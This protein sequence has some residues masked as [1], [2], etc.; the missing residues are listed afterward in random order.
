[1]KKIIYLIGIWCMT[2]LASCDYLNVDPY[3]ND[4][5]NLDS[6]FARKSFIERYL[7]NAAAGIPEESA[8]WNASYPYNGGSDDAFFTY[9]R[10]TYYHNYFLAN[11]WDA[12]TSYFSNWASHYQ[13][14]RKANTILSRL[15]ECKDATAIEKKNIMGMARFL[16]GYFYYKLLEQY[17]PVVIVPETPQQFD[18]PLS[19]LAIPRSTYDEC[20][21]YI[22]NDLT[23][24]AKLLPEKQ[25]NTY[26]MRPTQGAAL[27]VISR[28]RLYAASPLYNGNRQF[29]SGW[30]TKDGKNFISPEENNRKWA[31]A[32]VAALK[33]IRLAEDKGLYSLHTKPATGDTPTLPSNVPSAEFP[34]GAGGIDPYHSYAD[35]FN[36][37]ALMYKNT[38]CIWG[39]EE[40]TAIYRLEQTCHPRSSGGW[41][42]MNAPQKLVD[43]YYMRD[44]G[45]IRKSGGYYN[46]SEI[47]YTDGIENFS[48]YTLPSGTFKMYANREYR[49]YATIMFNGAIFQGLSTSQPESYSNFQVN[50]MADGND[51]KNTANDP[52]DRLLSGY[53]FRKYT[54]PDDN[55]YQ[56]NVS[57]KA[58]ARFRY[59]EIL[60]NYV[61]ALNELTGTYTI[62]GYTVKRDLAEIK[63]YFNPVHYRAG[64]PGLSSEDTKDAETL[65]EVILKERYLEFAIEGRRWHDQ[66]RWKRLEEDFQAFEGMNV[67]ALKSQP[68]LFYRRTRISEPNARRNYDRR[69]YFFPIPKSDMDKNPNLIQNPG[70]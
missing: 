63:K 56:G 55:F 22:C 68:N 10:G 25:P 51:G 67:E 32:A 42:G 27:A 33:V 6:V 31:E 12:T 58:F 69:L 53:T 54:H 15:D 18:S 37:E 26:W 62:D 3:F 46:Y 40:H 36:G 52:D 41:N 17:G 39:D 64:L 14:I 21:E 30:Q 49:F 70:W 50:Y 11:E 44:G 20:V 9:K 5:Q 45:T 13:G 19:E 29:Y 65:R 38:E 16:R 47:G 61:E 24:A 1:M 2:C 34:D 23:E 7:W 28:L 57:N 43:A 60:L 48:G 8:V 4:M 59:A 35:M 66:R